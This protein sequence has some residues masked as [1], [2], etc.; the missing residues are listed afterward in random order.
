[1]IAMAGWGVGD[2][3]VARAVRKTD[4]LTVLVWSQMIGLIPYF[5]ILLLSDSFK[6]PSGDAI[7]LVFTSA[8]MVTLAYFSLYK[9]LQVGKVS[10][11]TPISACWTIVTVILSS[12]FL[13]ESLSLI[14]FLAVIL[15]IT[16][17]VIASFKW[18]EAR[19]SFRAGAVGLRYAFIAMMCLGIYYVFLDVLVSELSWFMPILLIRLFTV[20][21]LFT[22]TLTT[23]NSISFPKEV[24]LLVILIGLLEF[25]AF[26][27]YGIGINSEYTAIV[28]P[29][30]ATSPV[31]TIMLAQLLLGESLDTNQKVG[32]VAVLIALILLFL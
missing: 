4:P 30:S 19:T 1:M 11:I 13:G 14:Q 20:T 18:G 2:F 17:G 10:L 6:I 15:A 23:Q 24:A 3:V 5:P 31:V 16:G 12:I 22:Y 21:Y 25:I 27:S 7:L 8:L 32:V 9:G 26:F 28:A 29:I